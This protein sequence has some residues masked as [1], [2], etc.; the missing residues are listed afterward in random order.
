M[1]GH[2]QACWGLSR[3]PHVDEQYSVARHPEHEIV[4]L[5]WHHGATQGGLSG[6]LVGDCV[7]EPVGVEEEGAGLEHLVW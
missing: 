3:W 5:L 1:T 4:A 2:T 7:A 6:Q